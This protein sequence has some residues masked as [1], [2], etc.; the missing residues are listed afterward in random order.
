[1]QGVEF[2]NGDI[3]M[4]GNVFVPADFDANRTYPTIVVVHPG[5]GVKEQTA[6]VYAQRLADQG[7]VTLAFD[8]SYQGASGGM[9]RFLDNPMN[10]VG[11]IYSAVD[12]LTTLPYVDD[13]N[14]G[15]LGI[16]AGGGVTIKAS[17][18]DPR[19]RSVATVS[20]VDIGAAAAGAGTASHISA[21]DQIATL[22][23]VASTAHRR[24]SGSR[25][26][27]RALRSGRR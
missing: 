26:R 24:S 12:Y 2:K 23:A 18:T 4:A 16:C 22:E 14:I 11:D 20:A 25:T 7:F 1:M 27:L 9:P 15:I 21:A 6:G 19:I 13:A 10:R 3:T 5:G 8:A 17:T